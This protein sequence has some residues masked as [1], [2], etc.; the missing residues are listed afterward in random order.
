MLHT[1]RPRSTNHH[2]QAS[3]LARLS[4]VIGHDEF[5]NYHATLVL[6][7]TSDVAPG[8]RELQKTGVAGQ[9][10]ER[11]G[12]ACFDELPW[13]WGGR[14]SAFCPDVVNNVSVASLVLQVPW[15]SYRSPP[16]RGS[17]ND[18]HEVVD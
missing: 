12:G 6:L 9:R 13:D 16:A 17:K 11:I 3:E 8:A 5:E 7:G 2:S 14:G 10:V 15:L 18:G 4:L 1:A